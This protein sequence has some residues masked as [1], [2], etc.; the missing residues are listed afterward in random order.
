MVVTMRTENAGLAAGLLGDDLALQE[1]ERR[2]SQHLDEGWTPTHRNAAEVKLAT[3]GVARVVGMGRLRSRPA[4]EVLLVAV[5]PG[6]AAEPTLEELQRRFRFTRREAEVAR[7]LSR[8]RSNKEIARDLGVTYYTARRHTE[9]V[10]QKLGVSG[11][12][13]VERALRTPETRRGHA[14]A[15]VA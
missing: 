1:L 11:R 13:E 14:R 4:V 3:G 2:I 12:W 6:T 5:D 15:A 9:R 8:R 10:L 7:L